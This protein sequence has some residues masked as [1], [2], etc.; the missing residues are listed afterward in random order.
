MINRRDVLNLGVGAAATV[1]SSASMAKDDDS[2]QP[3]IPI[4]DTNV[5]LFHWPF[6][7]LP[8]DDTA[9]LVKKLRSLG[10]TQAWAGS[11]EGLFHRDLA[12][13]NK[14]VADECSRHAEL[15]PIGTINPILPDWEDDMNRCVNQH[16]M[17]AV[18]IYPNYHQY[19]L[20]DSRFVQLLRIA[21]SYGLLVQIAVAMEDTRTQSSLIQVPDVDLTP[22]PKALKSVSRARVQILNHRLRAPQAQELAKTPGVYFDTARVDATDGVPSLI[23][24]VSEERVLFGSHAPFLIFEAAL[25]RVHESDLLS[26]ESFAAVLGG[27]VKQLREAR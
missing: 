18:R 6:R 27:N 19:G 26:Q 16:F 11:F 25:I 3:A 23:K 10:V 21:S 8:L 12:A 13:V 7:R 20:D 14:R 24:A 1:F 22:L 2:Q 4:V 5:S 17:S 9:A 15:S